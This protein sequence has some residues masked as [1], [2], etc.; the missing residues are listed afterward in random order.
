MNC[1]NC[2]LYNHS[3]ATYCEHCGSL[4]ELR[5]GPGCVE[6]AAAVILIVVFAPVGLCGVVLVFFSASAG[7]AIDSLLFGLGMAVVSGLCLFGAGKLLAKK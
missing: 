3:S 4:L 5:R 6:V 1:P 2:S 7:T